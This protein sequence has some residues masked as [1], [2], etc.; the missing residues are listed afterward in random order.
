MPQR[1]DIEWCDYSSNP[2]KFDRP[3]GKRVNFCV[4]VSPGCVNCYASAITR[5]YCGT[6]SLYKQGNLKD[7]AVVIH[8]RELKHML[9]FRPAAP[10]GFKNNRSRPTVFV[11]DMTDLFGPWVPDLM[12]DQ[13]FTVMALRSDVDWLVLTKRPERAADYLSRP[14]PNI[15]IGTSVEDQKRFDERVPQLLRIPAAVRFLSCEPLLE[16]IDLSLRAFVPPCPDAPLI[17][18]VI[19]G[20]ESGPRSR[21]CETDWLASIVDQCAAADVPCF[22][23]Q[24]GTNTNHPTHAFKGNA[25]ADWP[26]NLKVRQIPNPRNPRPAERIHAS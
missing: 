14:F 10:D 6:E 2:I 3:D 22:V 11:G 18:W 13:L 5:R 9:T 16:R 7:H 20:G 23:K 15:W 17:H 19:A 4:P 12:L 1:T 24:L 26:A 21:R 8:E 25:V